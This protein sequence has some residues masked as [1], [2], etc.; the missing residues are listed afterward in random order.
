MKQDAWSLRRLARNVRGATPS[1]CGLRH[2]LGRPAGILTLSA[3]KSP[4][5]LLTHNLGLLVAP[6][7]YLGTNRQGVVAEICGRIRELAPDVV[8]LCEVFADGERDEIRSALVDLYPHSAE[9]PDEADLES[10]GGLLVLSKT[11]FLETSAMIYRDCDGP[12]CLAN[13]GIIHTRIQSENW[14]TPLDLFYTHMQD[15]TTGNG[16][17]T[18]Y[19]QLRRMHQ[20]M[21]RHANPAWPAIVM[22]DLNIP[23]AV[24]RHYSQL[25]RVLVGTMDCWTVAGNAPASGATFVRD[26]NFYEDDDDRPTRDERLDYV[27][28][29]AGK[30]A[31]PL[32][33]E[34]EVVRFSHQ[35]RSISDHFGLRA[36]FDQ[37]AVIMP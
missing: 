36:A 31:A 8:G 9:G 25:L 13:K 1:P 15:I 19:S 18:L 33:S 26:N 16:V 12:D 32:L 20:F 2:V 35:G 23:G 6:A 22:G 10:D 7:P 29:R 30:H 21:K 11:P 37:V 4:M 14:A 27:L 17:R 3:K 34:I 28:L 24:T 5:S